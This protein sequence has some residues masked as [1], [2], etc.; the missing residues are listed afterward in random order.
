M[1]GQLLSRKFKKFR[2]IGRTKH[3]LIYILVLVVFTIFWPA[4]DDKTTV[5]AL[6]GLIVGFWMGKEIDYSFM[7]YQPPQNKLLSILSAVI[8]L[9]GF[10]LIN[11]NIDQLFSLV[12]LYK[13]IEISIS[14][15][16]LGIYISFVAPSIL[17]LMKLQST[18]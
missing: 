6:G 7:K 9:I 4:H 1:L 10:I 17:Y 18:R 12:S 11:E 3:F 14:S 8:A 13:S 15:F 2:A 5:L 16:I